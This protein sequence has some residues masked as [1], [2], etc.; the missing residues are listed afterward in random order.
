MMAE[1]AQD[2]MAML[3]VEKVRMD[4]IRPSNQND[5]IY[6][7]I[8]EDRLIKLANDIKRNGLINPLMVSIDNVI[9]DGHTRYKAMQYKGYK[10]VCVRRCNVHS[11]DPE[12]T[13]LLVS[14]N[15]QRIKTDQE[16]TREIT[17]TVDKHIYSYQQAIASNDDITLES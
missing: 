6:N 15:D 12:F 4:S 10:F 7:A 3:P 5:H 1:P 8:H 17:A 9:I 11:T 2:T 14:A 13:A 16:K